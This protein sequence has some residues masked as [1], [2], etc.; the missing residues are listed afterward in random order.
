VS[1]GNDRVTF[2][3]AELR[4]SLTAYTLWLKRRGLVKYVA[5]ADLVDRFIEDSAAEPVQEELK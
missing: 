5:P 3:F 1:I 4:I 2:T